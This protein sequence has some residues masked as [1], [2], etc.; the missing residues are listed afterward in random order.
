M[1]RNHQGL[2]Q[3]RPPGSRKP[4]ILTASPAAPAQICYPL[5]SQ[6]STVRLLPYTKI[7]SHIRRSGKTGTANTPFQMLMLTELNHQR[8]SAKQQDKQIVWT[9]WD[10][11]WGLPSSSDSRNVQ[12]ASSLWVLRPENLVCFL[13]CEEKQATDKQNL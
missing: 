8:K 2:Q 11:L 13:I 4:W 7:T 9:C 3:M 12:V 6:S 10:G 5:P 1:V